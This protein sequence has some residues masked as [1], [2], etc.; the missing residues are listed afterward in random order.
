MQVFDNAAQP[1][2]FGAINLYLITVPVS[3][4]EQKQ[5]CISF[6]FESLWSGEINKNHFITLVHLILKLSF[7]DYTL[8]WIS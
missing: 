7:D 2:W 5:C 1:S 6:F 8:H 4:R 3:E